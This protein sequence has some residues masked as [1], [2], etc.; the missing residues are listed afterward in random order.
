MSLSKAI[1]LTVMKQCAV[2]HIS[3]IYIYIYTY[4]IY[5]HIYIYEPFVAKNPSQIF[6]LILIWLQNNCQWL[7][8]YL[9]PVNYN[10]LPRDMP[11]TFFSC[12]SLNNHTSL[13]SNSFREIKPHF[14]KQ[15]K[16]G[17]DRAVVWPTTAAP[18]YLFY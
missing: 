2:I 9:S 15:T 6:Q 11:D 18:I 5:V 1:C 16:P 17:L 12:K 13:H 4:I 7:S 8:W 3:V 14:L 10:A